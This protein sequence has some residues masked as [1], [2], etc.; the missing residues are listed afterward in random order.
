MTQNMWKWM[1]GYWSLVVGIHG[2][3]VIFDGWT[4]HFWPIVINGIALAL[5]VTLYYRRLK[6]GAFDVKENRYNSTGS[7]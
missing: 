5:Y 2:T 6:S 7:P 3:Y 1:I 4:Y